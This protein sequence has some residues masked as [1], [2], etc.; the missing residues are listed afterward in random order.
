MRKKGGEAVRERRKDKVWDFWAGRSGALG[1]EFVFSANCGVFFFFMLQHSW[2]EVVEEDVEGGD[3]S[4]C[5]YYG[6]GGV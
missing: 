6:F 3:S 2:R 5:L 4:M 1:L